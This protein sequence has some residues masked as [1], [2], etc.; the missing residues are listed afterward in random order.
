MVVPQVVFVDAYCRE[1]GG[2]QL[3][4]LSLLRGRAAEAS[5]CLLFQTGRFV[6]RAVAEGF[7]VDVVPYPNAL[8]VYG[9][10][11]VGASRRDRLRHSTGLLRH[12]L[13]VLSTLR[14][15]RVDVL[16][17]SNV[18]SVLSVALASRVLRIPV[19]MY[20]QIQGRPSHPADRLATSLCSRVLR[21]SERVS[22]ARGYGSTP[23]VETVPIAVDCTA[24][25]ADLDR[26]VA[27]RD[28]RA[29]GPLRV[30]FVGALSDR[31][32]V[33]ELL[34]AVAG[35]G[36]DT[37]L[38]LVGSCDDAYRREVVAPRAAKAAGRI[39][40]TGVRSDLADLYRSHDLLVLPS[41]DE[42]VPRVIIEAMY[43]GLPVASTAVGGVADLVV[44]GV[45]GFVIASPDADAIAS[46]IGRYR[47]LRPAERRTM[48]DAAAARGREHT[49]LEAFSARFET[50]FASAAAR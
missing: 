2:A 20:L 46:A 11:V 43:C 31:K 10:A 3:T 37:V 39:T 35:L 13:R 15:R 18:R 49:D 47:A 30:L 17:C 22:V 14:G 4:M 24:L 48:S 50:V 5:R 23:P 36:D 25:K 41:R 38:T 12:N 27:E 40:A 26:P 8:N 42:G 28:R 21:I 33:A 19:V 16:Y 32:G 44:D 29:D 9:G 1:V 6:D 34:D 7:P 45:T